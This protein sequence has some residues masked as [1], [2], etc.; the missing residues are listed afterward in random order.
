MKFIIAQTE[1][2]VFDNLSF[3]PETDLTNSSLPINEFEARIFTN[4]QISYGQWAQ[5]LDDNNKLWA[6]FWL[7]YA[8][9]I[10]RDDDKQTYIVRIIGQSPIAF[11]ERVR[12]PAEFLN[13]S[14]YNLIQDVLDYVG[15]MGQMGDII[16]D[17]VV[18]SDFASV[19]ISG[20][21]PEQTARERLQ[22]LLMTAGGYVQSYFDT[23]IHINKVS[24]SGGAL[25]PLESTFWKPTVTFRDYVTKI[26]IHGYTYIEG[27]PS[28]G[29]TS[30]TDGTRTWIQTEQIFTLTNP[31]VPSGVPENEIEISGV[32]I[33]SPSRAGAVAE[34]LIAYYFNRIEVDADVIN[35]GLYKPGDRVTVYAEDDQLYVG[36]IDRCDFMFGL[37]TRGRLH[38]TGAQAVDV[39]NLTVIYKWDAY[40]IAKRLYFLPKNYAYSIT[41]EY[42]DT[43]IGSH[44]Y[45]FRPT[46]SE[47][48]GTLTAN[49][50]KIVNVE[51][52]LDHYYEDT[53]A[54]D[55]IEAEHGEVV[56]IL[57]EIYQEERSAIEKSYK[58]K[59]K[60]KTREKLLNELEKAY[61]EDI[62]K[63]RQAYDLMEGDI[64]NT[65]YFLYIVSVD[66]VEEDTEVIQ[67]EGTVIIS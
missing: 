40:E 61:G 6:N 19:Q 57:S 23:V 24:T 52:A 18:A 59:N 22:W 7:R 42:I 29:E 25:I 17:N 11:L 4:N 9:R 41:T 10:G 66:D 30:V 15:N 65:Q 47:I 58:G 53:G 1:Y 34:N 62:Q 36:Y 21:A 37:Q 5:L 27:T 67:E 54:R 46:I 50:T 32:T 48:T 51:V 45:V 49:A 16:R 63:A 43:F 8:E 3:L 20:F 55:A 28:S 56:R 26:K 12:L 44:R 39:A 35:N 14:A 60:K 13:D 38:L 64:S 2:R 31:A 33:I